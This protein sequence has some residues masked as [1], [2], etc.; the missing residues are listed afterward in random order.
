MASGGTSVVTRHLKEKHHINPELDSLARKRDL[1]GTAI[2]AAVLHHAESV[3]EAKQEDEVKKREEVFGHGLHKATLEYLYLQ[4]TVTQNITFKQVE[5]Q[6]FRTFLEYINPVANRLLPYS[7]DTLRIHANALFEEG[8]TRLRHI[9]I[10]AISDI[11][12]TCD[13]WS[14]PNHLGLLAILAHFTSEKL[15]LTTVTLALVE[16]QGEHSGIN[17]AEVILRVLDDYQIRGKVGYFMMDNVISNDSLVAHVADVLNSDG[18][19]YDAKQRRLRC[20]GHVINLVVQAFLFGDRVNDYEDS[21]EYDTP[22]EDELES[23]RKWGPLGKL[24]NI[25]TWIMGS[26]QRIQAWK[27]RSSLMPRRDQGTRWN[28]WY[29]MIDQ[30]LRGIKTP[31]T[32][33]LAE[34]PALTKDILSPGDWLTLTYVRDFLAS[35][36]ATTKAIEGRSATLEKVLPSLDFL[37]ER[38]D[39]AIIRFEDNPFMS[40]CLQAGYTKLLNYWNKTDRAPVYVAAI[41]LDPTLKYSYFDSWKPTWQSDIKEK[42]QGL[43]ESTY[44]PSATLHLML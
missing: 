28:S 37:A 7:H 12:I 39:D 13:M 4:W 30:A 18:I 24:H 6:H 36:L 20:N 29:E 2:H 34:E 35:F 32:E 25:C 1:N 10:S 26:S 22:T 43:W 21:G 14:S 23:W 38:F 27:K 42:M 31:L 3:Q 41:V 9:L 19:I 17:Q 11:H 8:K 40:S 33:L 15:Q 5:Y 44:K 16:L